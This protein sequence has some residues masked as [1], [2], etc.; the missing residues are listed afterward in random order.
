MIGIQLITIL[1]DMHSKGIVHRDLCPSNILMGVDEIS[2]KLILI[3][4][5]A[6]A[7]YRDSITE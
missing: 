5:D 3:D 2:H 6:A 1:D 4:F 7:T